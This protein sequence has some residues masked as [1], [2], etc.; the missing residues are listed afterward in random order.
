MDSRMSVV[1]LEKEVKIKSVVYRE[2]PC[3]RVY[4]DTILG[5]SQKYEL[6][7][8]RGVVGIWREEGEGGGGRGGCLGA[9]A[10]QKPHRAMQEHFTHYKGKHVLTKNW[11]NYMSV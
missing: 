4:F 5:H 8:F 7:C 1:T 3:H 9:E 6:T 10:Q 11:K 2:K